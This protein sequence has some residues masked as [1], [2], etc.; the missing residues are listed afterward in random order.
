MITRPKFN[1]NHLLEGVAQIDDEAVRH[2]TD[3]GCLSAEQEA[4]CDAA[5]ARARE[6]I[7]QRIAERFG[8]R[9]EATI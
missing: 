3:T 1:A 7:K 6:Q 2:L 5:I 4:R 8:G 9:W